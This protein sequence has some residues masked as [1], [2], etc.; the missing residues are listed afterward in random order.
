MVFEFKNNKKTYLKGTRKPK[1]PRD[2]N[3]I[4]SKELN[5]RKITKQKNGQKKK[6]K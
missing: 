6:L 1:R 4:Y 5:H 3:Y 2:N